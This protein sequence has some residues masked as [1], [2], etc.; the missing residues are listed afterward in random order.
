MI[1]WELKMCWI[2]PGVLAIHRALLPPPVVPLSWCPQEDKV[3]D[4]AEAKLACEVLFARILHWKA[5]CW[6]HSASSGAQAHPV[7]FPLPQHCCDGLASISSVCFHVSCS[8]LLARPWDFG[9]GME[10][11]WSPGVC[12]VG[13]ESWWVFVAGQSL[14]GSPQYNSKAK[15]RFWEHLQCVEQELLYLERPRDEWG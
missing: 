8:V 11:C 12:R 14:L 4:H 1:K 7:L 2:S 15:E 9:R 10:T 5:H 6:G 13:A 3:W